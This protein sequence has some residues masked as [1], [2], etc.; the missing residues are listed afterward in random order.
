MTD[1]P[2]WGFTVSKYIWHAIHSGDREGLLNSLG[3][4]Q[5][6]LI[7]WSPENVII[8]LYTWQDLK[9]D[10]NLSY[11]PQRLNMDAHLSWKHPG[12]PRLKAIP[13]ILNEGLWRSSQTSTEMWDLST[14]DHWYPGRQELSQTYS[15][16]PVIACISAG[17]GGPMEAAEGTEVM[18]TGPP[19]L[20]LHSQP[21]AAAPHTS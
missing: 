21:Q 17:Q 12:D 2:L 19:S 15:F 5:P 7:I 14:L 9:A 11:L 10:D 3:L 6:D 8:F 4:F 18:G 20:P 16:I 1:V 13:P